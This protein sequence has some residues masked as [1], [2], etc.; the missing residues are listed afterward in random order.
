MT[1]TRREARLGKILVKMLG[2]HRG[3]LCEGSRSRISRDSTLG[4][5]LISHDV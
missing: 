4:H 1:G 2:D 3:C 5:S